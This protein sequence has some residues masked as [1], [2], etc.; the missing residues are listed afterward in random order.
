MTERV[1][2]KI[3]EQQIIDRQTADEAE[4]FRTQRNIRN[5]LKYQLIKE[6]GFDKDKAKSLIEAEYKMKPIREE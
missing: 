5:T 1:L 3:E 4:T 6:Y 2:T